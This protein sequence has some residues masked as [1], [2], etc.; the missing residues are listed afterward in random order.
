[1]K[2]LS[3]VCCIVAVSG[4]LGLM[5]CGDD[6][7]PLT[8]TFAD[9]P[10]EPADAS[11]DARVPDAAPADAMQP[12]AGPST[13]DK[14]TSLS[15]AT[16]F[17]NYPLTPAFL[18]SI[19]SY[20]I[21][22]VPQ[23]PWC[24]FTATTEDPGATMMVSPDGQHF[25][26]LTSGVTSGQ[27]PLD[28]APQ[29]P[30][31]RV[32]AADGVTSQIYV[33]D[34]FNF[35]EQTKFVYA[36]GGDGG[37]HE[38]PLDTRSGNMYPETQSVPL[39]DLA[40]YNQLLITP[41]GKFIYAL[42]D[43][44]GNGNIFGFSADPGTGNL[45]AL[46][47]VNPTAAGQTAITGAI[48]ADGTQL[49]VVDQSGDAILQ[50]AIGTDGSLT[51]LTGFDLSTIQAHSPTSIAVTPN[52]KF[53]YVHDHGN[54]TML[55][56]S[57]DPTTLAIAPLLAANPDADSSAT[58]SMT[59]SG[60]NQF[61]YEVNGGSM[62]GISQ[63]AIGDNG[64]LTALTPPEAS[65]AISSYNSIALATDA[66][67]AYVTDTLSDDIAQFSVDDGGALDVLATPTT[68]LSTDIDGPFIETLDRRFLYV[69]TSNVGGSHFIAQM[70]INADN[71]LTFDG[72]VEISESIISMVA[73]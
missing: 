29:S 57:V 17:G 8:Q 23:L 35:F 65:L 12:D 54:D 64:V 51:P 66:A 36:I 72:D 22:Q 30:F 24:T 28:I 20:D 14:L 52:G 69:A 47:S 71:T 68:T 16:S 61:L 42:T 43:L 48:T 59:A 46:D 37:I 33:V 19:T 53:L 45:T 55:Q 25:T 18:P 10:K 60:N 73:Y 3:I 4:A 1:M 5:A 26:P 27:L 31:I 6:A 67:H 32:T 70:T 34:M 56:F 50:Y 7:A 40:D 41:N 62:A 9:A 39:P 49:Y 2:S 21:G 44:E 13:D 11:V 38:W 63:Y 58:S 15:I